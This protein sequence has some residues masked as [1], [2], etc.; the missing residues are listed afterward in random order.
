MIGDPSGKNSE[1]SALPEA[2][3]EKNSETIRENIL[4]IFQNHEQYIWEKN[5]NT[6][7]LPPVKY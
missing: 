1:R 4:R 6:D 7:A 2:T 3:V 5:R